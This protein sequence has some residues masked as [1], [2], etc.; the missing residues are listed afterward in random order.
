LYSTVFIAVLYLNIVS[1]DY[2]QKNV[3]NQ[4]KE[5]VK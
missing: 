1:S 3:L 5:S 4:I 2:L